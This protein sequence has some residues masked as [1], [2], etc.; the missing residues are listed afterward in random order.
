MPTSRPDLTAVAESASSNIVTRIGFFMPHA[1]SFAPSVAVATPKAST[2]LSAYSETASIPL[3]YASH[4]TISITDFPVS[5]LIFSTF[6]LIADKSVATISPIINC[7][8]SSSI[9]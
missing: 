8:Q 7:L 3:P 1:R 2:K 4:L 5:A 6:R 9:L